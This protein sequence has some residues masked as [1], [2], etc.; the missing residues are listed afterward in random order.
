MYGI[1]CLIL[2]L[3]KISKEKD[4]K[5]PLRMSVKEREEKGGTHQIPRGLWLIG[6]ITRHENDGLIRMAISGAPL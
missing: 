5:F 4:G 2:W 1:T 6:P 3:I